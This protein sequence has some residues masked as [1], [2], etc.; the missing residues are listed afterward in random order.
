MKVA[1]VYNRD[2]RDVI[3]LFGTPNREK[4]GLAQVKRITDA[5]KSGG[6]QPKAFEADKQLVHRLEDFMPQVVSG[7]R[8]GLVFNVSNLIGAAVGLAAGLAQNAW[9]TW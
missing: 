7:E 1:V 3:N 6:H 4:I 8:P 2:S 9:P 5:L